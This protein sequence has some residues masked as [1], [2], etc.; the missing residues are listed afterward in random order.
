MGKSKISQKKEFIMKCVAN[1]VT[2]RPT[3]SEMVAEEFGLKISSAYTVVYLVLSDEKYKVTTEERRQRGSVPLDKR[4]WNG[5]YTKKSEDLVD[6]S[7][8]VGTNYSKD[9]D[10]DLI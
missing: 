6:L 5:R 2:H 9:D 3:I 10:D 8:L 7:S 1:G 4:T